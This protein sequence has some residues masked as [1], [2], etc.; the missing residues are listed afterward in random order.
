MG[1]ETEEHAARRRAICAWQGMRQRCFNPNNPAFK[2]YGGRGITVCDR[3]R[4]DLH[5]FLSDMGYPPS[6]KHTIDRY[7]N[8]D[9]NYEPG[10][11]RWATPKE[12]ARNRCCTPM[13]LIDGKPIVAADWA[14]QMGFSRYDVYLRVVRGETVIEMTLALEAKRT[15]QLNGR[16]RSPLKGRRYASM[17]CAVCGRRWHFHPPA[18][19]TC[20]GERWH[21]SGYPPWG[22]EEDEAEPAK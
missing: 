13:L 18:S 17:K 21:P 15:R 22:E 4:H 6:A 2:R 1:H 5:A 3:W 9:G 8:N 19:G 20:P 16:R 7:P 10:N 12:Q 11:C 14:D